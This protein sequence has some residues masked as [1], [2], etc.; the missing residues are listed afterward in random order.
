[1]R[2]KLHIMAVGAHILDAEL[3]CG[4][5][6]LLGLL[7]HGFVFP[8][9]NLSNQYQLFSLLALVFIFSYNG[10]KGKYPQGKLPAKLTQYGFYLFYPVHQ[11][12]LW[13]IR[14]L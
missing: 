13:L 12:V 5:T 9:F 7:G 14:F 10:E 8:K 1:M 2:E 4:K 3:S 11:L 6:L